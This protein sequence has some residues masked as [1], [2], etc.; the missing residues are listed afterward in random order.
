M[1][2]EGRPGRALAAL[3]AGSA[4]I[5]FSA[6]FVRLVD[7]E[8]TASAVY[9]MGLGGAVLALIVLVRGGRL[10]QGR[11]ALWVAALGAFLFA[12]DLYFWHR[13]ILYVG[14]GLATLLANF[15]VFILAVVGVLLFSERLR[16]QTAIS[17]PLALLGLGL[18]VVGDWSALGGDYQAGV[19]L[20]LATAVAYSGYILALRLARRG[21]R[22]QSSLSDMAVLSLLCAAML[23]PVAVGHGEALYPV[24]LEDLGWLLAYGIAAQVLGWVLISNALAVLP[25]SRVGLVLLMQPTLAFVWD[26][27]IFDRGFTGLELVGAGLALAAIYLGAQRSPEPGSAQ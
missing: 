13:S 19:W 9:R 18:L 4:L 2:L 6:V 12:L 3:L 20:G 7:V 8:P 23:V 11:R 17:I 27:L 22:S 16:W 15:Q 24:S 21:T 10:W 14:P 25:A 5:S 1:R 26:V